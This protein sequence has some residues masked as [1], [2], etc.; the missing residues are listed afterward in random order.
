MEI[1]NY[2]YIRI[3][4][5]DDGSIALYFDIENDKILGIGDEMNEMVEDAYMNGYNWDAFLH[6]SLRRRYQDKRSF[7]PLAD[8]EVDSFRRRRRE[9]WHRSC[10]LF[11]WYRYL[12]IF[13]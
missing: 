8:I 1:Q 5:H 13:G 11:C 6:S 10:F 4:N 2:D 12:R 3:F 9:L 7:N